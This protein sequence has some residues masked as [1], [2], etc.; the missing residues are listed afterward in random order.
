MK[1]FFRPVIWVAV[2]LVS[3]LLLIPL[4]VQA[5]GVF[6]YDPV[7]EIVLT[8]KENDP[9]RTTRID[10]RIGEAG[11]FSHNLEITETESEQ[12]VGVTFRV[13]TSHEADRDRII[14]VKIADPD[15]RIT[16]TT[17]AIT[18]PEGDKVVTKT[19]YIEVEGD[20]LHSGDSDVLISGAWR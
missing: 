13:T 12:S 19:F 17:F 1:P 16:E 2:G 20:S 5:V 15:N 9:K 11:E 14:D 3:G 10:A 6:F 8:V 4:V 7:G 18:M